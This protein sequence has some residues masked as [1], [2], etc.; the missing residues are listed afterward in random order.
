VA[1]TFQITNVLEGIREAVSFGKKKIVG[2]DIGSSAIKVAEVSVQGRGK[3]RLH[4]FAH[5]PLPEG[6]IIEDEIIKGDEIST[7]IEDAIKEASCV[8]HAVCFGMAG[9][10]SIT[11]KIQV[12]GGS[13]DE[14]DDQVYWEIEQFIPF[15]IDDSAI[16][17]DVIGENNA[18]GVDVVFCA[19]KSDAVDNYKNLFEQANIK[20]KIVDTNIAS[21]INVFEYNYQDKVKNSDRS[22]IILDFGAQRTEFIVYREGT[23]SF[24]KEMNIGGLVITEEIQRKMGVK[25]ESA[26]DLKIVGDSS[27]NLPEEVLSI[28]DDVVE[29]FLVEAKKTLDFYIQ[30]TSDETIDHIYVTGGSG[31]IPGFIE[32]LASALGHEVSIFNP[33]ENIDYD[34]H[35]STE[36]INYIGHCGAVA[37]GLAMRSGD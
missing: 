24:C 2:I 33:L 37:L 14:V 10:H 23:L 26:E 36:E 6:A 21:L 18:G 29:V 27:G 35:F 31:Q 3:V 20:V 22:Y 13:K 12:A 19:A 30:S 9:Q 4:R 15:D 28:I 34:K 1:E 7:A 32:G 16:S 11:K 17:Y 5:I 25:Y 8:G